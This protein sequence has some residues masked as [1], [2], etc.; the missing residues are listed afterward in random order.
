MMNIHSGVT[1]AALP[2]LDDAEP[3]S[4]QLSEK[5]IFLPSGDHSG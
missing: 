5:A 4:E 1:V 2:A 3:P